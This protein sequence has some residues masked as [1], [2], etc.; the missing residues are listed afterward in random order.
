VDYI[1]TQKLILPVD[2]VNALANGAIRPG[3]EGKMLPEL[4]FSLKPNAQIMKGTL[5]QL[6][7]LGSNK[8]ERPV[9]YTSGGFSGSLGL[10]RF[11]RT[12]GLAYRIVP[13]ETPYK[14]I[15]EMGSIDTDTLY[16]RLMNT[17]EWGRMN[18]E[19]VHLDYYTIRTFSVIRFRSLYTRLALELL[20]EE[21]GEKA[22]KVLDRCMELAPNKVLP[23]D[24]YVSGI[25]I[26][27]GQ[28]GLTHY[29]GIIE[30]YYLCGETEKANTIL[31]EHYASL[32]D[33]YLYLN[34]MKQRH[35]NSLQRE[36]NEILFQLEELGILVKSYKQT[37]LMLELGLG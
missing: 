9:Y 15:I 10:E 30:A 5:A 19:D 36:M 17:F 27:D 14:S 13:I 28:G 6:D 25:T 7:V 35:K 18:Q 8:W 23:F 34:S 24:Q 16:H 20:K 32:S 26:P 33:K 21:E 1:P 22:I 31:K 3:E 12:E 4:K 2:T 29:E 37:E 11:Y